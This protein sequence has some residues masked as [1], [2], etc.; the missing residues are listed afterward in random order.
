MLNNYSLQMGSNRDLNLLPQVLGIKKSKNEAETSTTFRTRSSSTKFYSKIQQVIKK[1]SED[2]I[3]EGS[4]DDAVDVAVP[5]S[6]GANADGNLPSPSDPVMATTGTGHFDLLPN[7]TADTHTGSRVQMAPDVLVTAKVMP[8][9]HSESV[10]LIDFS[11]DHGEGNRDSAISTSSS[12]RVSS[13]SSSRSS[14]AEFAREIT[15]RSRDCGNIAEADSGFDLTGLERLDTPDAGFRKR[16]SMITDEEKRRSTISHR[17]STS[18]GT[19]TGAQGDGSNRDSQASFMSFDGIDFPPRSGSSSTAD[20]ER[21]VPQLEKKSSRTGSLKWRLKG[22]RKTK[23]KD[24]F[25][26]E[27]DVNEHSKKKDKGFFTKMRKGRSRGK[28]SKASGERVYVK[29]PEKTLDPFD[30]ANR[31]PHPEVEVKTT[32]GL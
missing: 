30:I 27:D 19:I 26:G 9:E 20:D 18:S 11:S 24:Y 17:G 21:E 7:T 5:G 23:D 25:R 8:Q 16:T 29:L 6:G 4:G 10:D 3:D 13:F 28:P 1:E 31:L 22:R 12:A 32:K 14:G 15:H 2:H